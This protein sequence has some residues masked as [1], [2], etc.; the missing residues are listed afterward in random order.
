MKTKEHKFSKAIAF[1][2]SKVSMDRFLIV[3]VIGL[4]LA[5]L[6]SYLYVAYKNKLIASEGIRDT[7]TYQGKVANAQGVPPPDGLYDMR[8]KIYDQAESG[9]LLWTEIWNGTDQGSSGSKVNVIQGVFT[10]ELNSLCASWTGTCASN[11]GVTFASDSFY[12]QVELDYNADGTYEEIFLP[13]KRF[14]ATPYAM[15][16]EKV[17][18]H[19]AIDFVLK[20]GDT[21]TGDLESINLKADKNAYINYGGSGGWNL[22]YTAA[23]LPVSATPSWT[24]NGTQ[25]ESVAD[26]ILHLTDS[27]DSD[28]IYYTRAES[29]ISP[30]SPVIVEAR[31]RVTS[32]SGDNSPGIN[33]YNGSKIGAIQFKTDKIEYLY[34]PSKYYNID[35][36]Q[37]HL[38]KIVQLD[39]N[40]KVYVDGGGTAVIDATL[41]NDT[42]SKDIY[43]GHI[44]T[45]GIGESYWDYV[46]YSYNGEAGKLYFS[47]AEGNESAYLRYDSANSNLEINKSVK[48]LG[49]L[50][51][52]GK[53]SFDTGGLN[54]DAYIQWNSETNQIEFGSPISTPNS[55]PYLNNAGSQQDY[56]HYINS[57]K[58]LAYDFS[59]SSGVTVTDLAGHAN[60]TITNGAWKQDGYNGYGLAFG[61]TNTYVDFANPGLANATGTVEMWVKLNSLVSATNYLLTL[62]QNSSNHINI[63]KENASDL[64][65]TIGDSG[66]V[67]TEWNFPDTNW[68]HIALSWNSGNYEVFADG[69]S[70]KTGTYSILDVDSFT[71]FRLGSDF[72]G[73]NSFDGAIDSFA[74]YDTPFT[75]SEALSHYNSAFSNLYVTNELSD[76]YTTTNLVNLYA[77]PSSLNG[78]YDK[79]DP[80]YFNMNKMLSLAFSEGGGS[81]TTSEQGN[82]AGQINGAS[83]IKGYHG[84]ALQ[85]D[86]IDDNIDFPDS[87]QYLPGSSDF[88][89]D[90]FINGEKDLDQTDKRIISKRSGDIGFE[91]YFNSNNAITYFIGDGTNTA[92]GSFS[93]LN[94]SNGEWIN[95]IISFDRDGNASVYYNGWP[96]NSTDISSVGDISNSANLFIGSDATGNYFKGKLDSIVVFDDR[97]L[98][99]YDSY[100]RTFNAPETLVLSSRSVPGNSTN[101]ASINQS[102][103]G[104]AAIF[105]NWGQNNPNS[106]PLRVLNDSSFLSGDDTLYN[107]MSFGMDPNNT[108]VS[109]KWDNTANRIIFDH[110][111]QQTGDSYTNVFEGKT[112]M[113]GTTSPDESLDV[114]GNVKSSGWISGELRSM[115]TAPTTSSDSCTAGDIR[116]ASGF[117]YICV[118]TDTWERAETSGW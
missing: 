18:G 118:D 81:Q 113:G 21:M 47:G 91:I 52:S 20:E 90:F 34:D 85:F 63:Y 96:I 3:L 98:N 39:D 75:I 117:I 104:S 79:T 62:Q 99:N 78:K 36:T 86:G 4:Q 111:L 42:S 50:I 24:K 19:D 11:G 107:L 80:A 43:F 37:Y 23:D 53:L 101:F 108:F 89:V 46:R 41:T 8:F 103:D 73:T 114:T 110:G 30:T 32:C 95:V 54:N 49:D 57:H 9:N 7:L 82:N 51:S 58:I 14:T 83:W 1:L 74:I 67:D 112:R 27:S 105:A 92:S 72:G 60:G 44:G 76:G 102:S 84:Y 116:Y 55:L 66:A 25:T 10:V 29:N 12:L 97:L 17:D 56:T 109:L 5:L 68:H 22:E 94:V 69:A 71:I 13:R 88:S 26:G 61:L 64:Y 106:Y 38:I 16:A 65:I 70:V 93:G 6:I 40:I 33:I 35:M 48:S 28:A 115:G 87:S 2:R 15:N 45:T 31:V 100:A 77:L 59:D